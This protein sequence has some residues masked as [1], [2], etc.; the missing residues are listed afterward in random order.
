MR[1]SEL[2]IRDSW[3]EYVVLDA[4]DADGFADETGLVPLDPAT[5]RFRVIGW[6]RTHAEIRRALVQ[7]VLRPAPHAAY[8]SEA[9]EAAIERQFIFGWK[10][11]ELPRLE[12]K[13]VK[14]AGAAGGATDAKA[15]PP[16]PSSSDQT[17]KT[18]FEVRVVDEFGDALDGLEV[19]FSQTSRQETLETDGDGVVRWKDV[20][21]PSFASVKVANVAT[22]R[23]ML[24]P[25]Y[26][27]GGE[28]KTPDGSDVSKVLL[29]LD[30]PGK[31]LTAESPGVLV[32]AKPLS[33]VRLTGMHFDTNKCFLR[34]S[35]MHGIRKVASVYK[36]NP[37]GKLLIVGHTD[38]SGDEGY[39]L[40]LSLERAQA[41]KAYLSDDV[42]AWEAWY[43]DGKPGQKRWGGAET[44][45][46]IGALP[47]EKSVKG[48]QQWSNENRGT[49]LA[50]DG[51]AGPKTRRALIEAYMALDGTSLPKGIGVE[52]HGCG[53]FFPV[54]NAADSFGTDGVSSEADRRVELFCFDDDIQPPVPGPKA[55]RGEP[56]Y[57]EWNK[58]VTT[59]LDVSSEGGDGAFVLTVV[60]EEGTPLAGGKVRVTQNDETLFEGTL[61]S[62]GQVKI[63]GNDPTVPCDV[64]VDGLGAF[65]L[66]GGPADEDASDAVAVDEPAPEEGGT[67]EAFVPTGG[68]LAAPKTASDPDV[69][70]DDDDACGSDVPVE[71]FI[72]AAEEYTVKAGDRMETIAA[73]YGLTG[74]ELGEFRGEQASDKKN[75]ERLASGDINLIK[76]G[77][78]I[79]VPAPEED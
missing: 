1:S 78:K 35:A 77:E 39:N 30:D 17:T 65:T 79:M 23:E 68:V 18:W 73:K 36:A 56:E 29:G 34:E 46:M 14:I 16:P 27:K 25:R 49:D 50:V 45:H 60:D 2:R 13:P 57:I 62:L 4:W 22:L 74:K 42:A 64:F 10:V 53:E 15:S 21:G 33:R 52:V 67:S 11:F 66:S 51:A 70:P 55:T 54:T 7:A 31:A 41:V 26:A 59:E 72:G 44:M 9:D 71:P 37:A 40:D 43:G 3:N 20:E 58:Q 47:C 6:M 38:T 48:F 69:D 12:R 5:A 28:R 19:V 75:V 76:P 24:K 8:R 61:D 63:T 32:I